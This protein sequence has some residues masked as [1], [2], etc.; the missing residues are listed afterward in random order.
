MA[1]ESDF[2]RKDNGH[3]IPESETGRQSKGR[4][5]ERLYSLLKKAW[6]AVQG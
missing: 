1:Q 5:A 2:N 6:L 4:S 3:H